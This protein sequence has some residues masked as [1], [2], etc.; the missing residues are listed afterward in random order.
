[1][2]R[3]TGLAVAAQLLV[4]EQSLPQCEQGLSVLNELAEVWGVRS[5]HGGQRVGPA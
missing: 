1:M 2:A 3:G 4:P 5:F